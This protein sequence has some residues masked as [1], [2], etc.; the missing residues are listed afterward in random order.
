M[1]E[2]ATVAAAMA[3]LNPA[4]TSKQIIVGPTAAEKPE[5][6]LMPKLMMSNTT[7]VQGNRKM[8]KERSGL[9]KRATKCMSHL[10][11]DMTAA[12]PIAEQMA[13]IND[14]VV[15]DLS[16]C[17]NASNGSM[18][19]KVIAKPASKSTTGSLFS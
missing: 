4:R 5:K 2:Q 11:K 18:A 12:K 16:N 15:M 14:E 6:L 8:P 13:T 3:G 10:V 9:V 19:I 17:L 7:I 1:Q